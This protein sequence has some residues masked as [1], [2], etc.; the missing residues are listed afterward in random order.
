MRSFRIL[1]LLLAFSFP[2]LAET[3]SAEEFLEKV[4]LWRNI[5]ARR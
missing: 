3:F 2:A 5:A 4:D 1:F